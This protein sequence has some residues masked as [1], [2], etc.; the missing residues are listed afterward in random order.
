MRG[1]QA[2]LTGG[3]YDK[4][5]RKLVSVAVLTAAAALVPGGA[6]TRSSPAPLLTYA[7]APITLEGAPLSLGLCATDLDGNTFRV[8]EPQADGSPSWSPDGRSLAF[9]GPAM[10]PGEDHFRDLFVT[11][12]QGGNSR[13][14]TSGGGR[15]TPDLFAWS[16]DGSEVGGN[17]A[18]LGTSVFIANADGTGLRLLAATSYG[19]YVFGESWSPA[20]SRILLSRAASD[21]AA[22]AVSV[23]DA[24][25]TGER[26]LVADADLPRW[27]PDGRQFAYISLK[28]NG[29]AVAQA[30]GSSTHL[31]LQGANFISA[32]AWSPDGRQLAYIELAGEGSLGVVQADGSNARVLA[33]GVS[34]TPQ[35]SPDGSLIAFTRGS[36]AAPRVAVVK[37]DGSGLQDVAT[38]GLAASDPTWRPPAPMPSHRRPC[39]V[40]GTSRADVIHGTDRSDVIL[41][42]R[43]ADRVSGGGGNDVLV[44]GLGP[45]RLFGGSGADIFAARDRTRDFLF[46]DSG[47]DRAYADPFDRLTS[48]KRVH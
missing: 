4:G 43:G 29:L 48:V 46:G 26:T 16:P 38:G 36:A 30:D 17:W 8:S 35:W 28:A 14:L 5:V 34:G 1:L 7:V 9:I 11:D 20:G 47:S 40:R 21:S 45:D 24:G 31:L 13:D 42:G 19:S 2:S 39:V 32:P 37:P 18:G 41:A 22:T 6:A 12:A 10:P 3:N 23:I 33:T 27:S 44:G 25:G 15:G